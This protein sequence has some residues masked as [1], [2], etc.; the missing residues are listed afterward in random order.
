MIP[1]KTPTEIEKMRKAGECAAHILNALSDFL[2]PGIT[3]GEVDQEAA[4][5]MKEWGVRS[6]FLHYGR[7]K[8]PGHI[9][10]SLNEEVVHGIGGPRK[11]AYGDVVKMDVGIVMDGFIG[12]NAMS[13]P[14]GVIPPE[15]ER[16]LQA[17]ERIL[18]ESLAHA[19]AGRR[20]GDLCSFIEEQTR[21]AGYS[22]V[23]EFVGHGV[24]RKLHEEP[25]VP[26]YGKRGTGPKLKPGMTLAI[27]PMINQ[28]RPEIRVKDD[29]WTVVTKDGLPS[30]H[31]EHTI[32]ITKDA[33]EVLT[34]P[35][36]SLFS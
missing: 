24:G 27:E 30:A 19:R 7:P 21:A 23:R 3:T 10:I 22:V 9:C 31:F 32:L 12:D 4:R 1:I 26:N 16:L 33:P 18:H 13:V 14:V 35:R 5:L 15:T 28:G 8:F 6:A 2:A 17:T 25:Q 11:V 29:R 34:W 20:L 36:K